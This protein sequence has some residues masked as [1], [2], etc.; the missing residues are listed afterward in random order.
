MFFS[1]FF[2]TVMEISMCDLTPPEKAACTALN[3]DLLAIT[4]DDAISIF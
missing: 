4:S 2:S 3:P 1:N